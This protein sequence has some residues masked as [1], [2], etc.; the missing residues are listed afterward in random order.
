[1]TSD[2]VELLSEGFKELALFIKD[3]QE[4]IDS[5]IERIEK[6]EKKVEG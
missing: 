1:M 3:N 4:K 2:V 6:I 5:L